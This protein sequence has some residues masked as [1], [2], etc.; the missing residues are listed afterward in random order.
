MVGKKYWVILLLVIGL[1]TM[2]PGCE[3]EVVVD[4]EPDVPDDVDVP[5]ESIIV[6]ALDTEIDTMELDAFKSDAAYTLDANTQESPIDY[7]WLPGPEGTWK[8]SDE[9]IGRLAESWEI[10]EDNLSITFNIREGV[11]FYTGNPVNAEAFKHSYDRH[12]SLQ[13]GITRP[14]MDMALGSIDTG[15]SVDQVE[16]IDEYTVRLTLNEPNH[17]VLDYLSTKVIPIID[18]AITEEHATDDDPWAQEYWKTNTV[19]SG[20]YQLARHEPGVEWELT[21]YE[22]YWNRDA[23]KND[24]VI[25]K[26]IP[27]AE[28]RLLLLKSGEVDVVWGIPFKDMKDLEADPDINVVTFPSRS[29]DF[30]ILN[31]TIPPFDDVKVRQAVSYAI[32]YNDLIENA[33]YGYASELKSPFP[34][35]MA[36]ADFGYWPYGDGADYEKAKELLTEAGFPDGFETELYVH[37]GKQDDLDSA[38]LI[39]DALSNVGIDVSLNVVASTAFFDALFGGSAPMIIHYIYTYVND[40]FYYSFYCLASDGVANFS[41]Y[42]NPQVDELIVEGF[43]EPDQEKRIEMIG[44]IQRLVLEDAAYVNLYSQDL[45]FAISKDVSGFA[46]HVDGHPRFWMMEK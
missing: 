28:T 14:M 34:L 41:R 15:S 9:F 31:N 18:P 20:P 46:A 4:D 24:G 7:G 23:I 19:G 17:S 10:S 36:G 29:Q 38:M 13:G 22:E 35:S 12:I 43:F 42:S 11:T 8:S 45:V 2:S 40:P 3:S 39:Q 32:P 26:V 5:S 1:L 25:V 6:V 27:S 16:V 37:M 44:E 21:P 33:L 30:M